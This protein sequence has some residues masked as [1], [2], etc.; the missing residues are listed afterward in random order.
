[1]ILFFGFV[2]LLLIVLFVVFSRP[3]GQNIICPNV[4]CK[5]T[6]WANYEGRKSGCLLLILLCLGILPGII[7]L[8]WAGQRTLNCPKCGFKIQ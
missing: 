1:M 3:R 2:V 5:Y 8:L 7:Y 4:N 6:G